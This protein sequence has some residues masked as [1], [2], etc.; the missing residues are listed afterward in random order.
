[1]WLGVRLGRGDDLCSVIWGAHTLPRR[2][3]D[4]YDAIALPDDACAVAIGDIGGHGLRAAA[5]MTQTRSMLRV[6]L[7]KRR[8]SPSALLTQLD[9]TLQAMADTPITTACLARLRPAGTRWH[10]RWSTAG[11]PA[12]LLIVPGEPARYLE[13]DPRRR[14]RRCPR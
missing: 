3:G 7:Y 8:S 10:L 11:H 12:P 13:A 4:W 6:L 9:L 14:R 1:L 2:S 5:A